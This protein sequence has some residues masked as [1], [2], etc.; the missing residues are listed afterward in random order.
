MEYTLVIWTVVAAFGTGAGTY[1]P[2]EYR[3]WRPIAVFNNGGAQS[4]HQCHAAAEQLKLQKFECI[5]TK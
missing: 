3:D 4:L 5:R 2:Q 1:K